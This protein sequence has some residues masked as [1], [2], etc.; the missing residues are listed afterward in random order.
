[1]EKEDRKDD[2][3]FEVYDYSDIDIPVVVKEENFN[4]EKVKV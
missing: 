2:G 3:N 4:N 1:M